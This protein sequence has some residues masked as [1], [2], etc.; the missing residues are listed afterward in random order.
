MQRFY[1]TPIQIA[2]ILTLIALFVFMSTNSISAQQT[3]NF[4]NNNIEGEAIPRVMLT[5]AIDHLI[6][7]EGNITLL[8]TDTHLV[9]QLTNEGLDQITS[10][11]RS[12]NRD[13]DEKN[14][15]FADLLRSALSTS[16]YTLLDHGIAIPLDEI[17][18]AEFKNGELQIHAKNDTLI[19][20]DSGINDDNLMT[21]F[22]EKDAIRFTTSLN[23]F[24]K[25]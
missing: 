22:H 20:E 10:G 14:S 23:N 13:S 3:F 17:S 19:F 21:S 15:F 8:F 16:L 7:G 5:S 9:V 11:I 4:K 6:N 1:T 25:N 24:L 2:K 12:D 18:H